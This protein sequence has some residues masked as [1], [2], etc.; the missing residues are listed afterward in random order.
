MKLKKTIEA[1][2]ELG[3]LDELRR[4]LEEIYPIAERV[5]DLLEEFDELDDVKH[6][7]TAI[8]DIAD[9]VNK[10]LRQLPEDRLAKLAELSPPTCAN[11]GHEMEPG[12]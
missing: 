2:K 1:I 4:N 11:E 8:A 10:A 9:D 6:Q 7:L 3:D 5:R 12:M